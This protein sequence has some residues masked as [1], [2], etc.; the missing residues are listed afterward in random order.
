MECTLAHVAIIAVRA[1]DSARSHC[2]KTMEAHNRH[3]IASRS[4]DHGSGPLDTRPGITTETALTPWRLAQAWKYEPVLT[5]QLHT[6]HFLSLKAVLTST[7]A[8]SNTHKFSIDTSKTACCD[9]IMKASPMSTDGRIISQCRF[10]LDMRRRC[11]N[12]AHAPQSSAL[13][14]HTTYIKES[15]L[16][17]PA[18]TACSQPSPLP[19]VLSRQSAPWPCVDA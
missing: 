7:L 9:R 16:P 15:C 11:L 3:F 14:P 2:V 12:S 13:T 19:K 17:S 10:F 18:Q 6:G 8:Q 1:W 5:T 4:G